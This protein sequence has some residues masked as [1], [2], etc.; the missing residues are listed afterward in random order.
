MISLGSIVAQSILCLLAVSAA[1]DGY[2]AAGYFFAF[3][4]VVLSWLHGSIGWGQP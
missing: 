4:A 1:S 2:V 3:L